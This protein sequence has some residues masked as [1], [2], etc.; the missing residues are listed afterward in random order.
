MIISHKYKYLFIGLPFSASSAISKELH[1]KYSGEPFLRK[2]SLYYEF[3]KV[4]KKQEKDY[5][6]FAVLRNPM[7]IVMTAYE[8]MK[9]NVKGN[10]T[11]PHLFTENG[12]HITRTQREKFD[13]I[14]EKKATFQQYFKRF[15]HKPYD[16]TASLTL[17]DCDYVIRYENFD[18]D[19]LL[20]L[21][22]AGILNP[23]IL[24]VANKTAGKRQEISEYYTHEIKEEAISV[25]GPFL[26]KYKY[27]FPES[28][29]VVR[30]SKIS[31]IKF[32]FFGIL[33]RINQRYFKKTPRNLSLK[34]TI[35]GDMQSKNKNTTS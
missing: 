18:H 2:H 5:F 35:Y 7:D 26:E 23:R 28:W 1:L 16:N 22:K 34:G 17:D 31:K 12:G 11:N 3:K 21:K 6:V 14:H 13:Y 25:F 9:A 30:V 27:S 19:Y 32:L 15:F 20:A 24:P 4:A 33:R 29:G 10:F 8:K